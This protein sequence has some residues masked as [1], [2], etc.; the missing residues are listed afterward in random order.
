MQT[1][2]W[3]LSSKA[4]KIDQ[5]GDEACI[6]FSEFRVDSLGLWQSPETRATYPAG[7]HMVID[8]FG[9]DVV[10]VPEVSDQEF[11]FMDL[12]YWEGSCKVLGKPANGLSYTELV[13][14][15]KSE[16]MNIA[17]GNK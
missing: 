2:P 6:P 15:A 9:L 7:W 1:I 10:I 14:Y 12:A 11:R 16:L 17:S 13:G 5:A 3:K 8:Q 4:C